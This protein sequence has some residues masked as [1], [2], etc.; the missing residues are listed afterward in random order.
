MQPTKPMPS[1]AEP[2]ILAGL[3][4]PI[5]VRS[6]NFSER[7]P[8][9]LPPTRSG[10]AYTGCLALL[11]DERSPIGWIVAPASAD[12]SVSFDWASLGDLRPAE[13]NGP[14]ASPG[15][16]APPAELDLSVVVSTCANAPGLLACVE[17]LLESDARPREIVVV[18]NRPGSSTVEAELAER[19]PEESRIRYVEES[20]PGLSFARNAGLAVVQGELVA[21]T[22]D[23][24][25][26][27]RAWTAA[28]AE[29][30]ADLAAPD[31]LT[32]LIAPYELETPAQLLVEE[33]AGYGKGMQSRVYSLAAPPP[34]Q[35]LFPYA[36]G[37]YAS[38]ANLAFRTSFL[39][40]IGGFDPALGAGTRAR[41]GED[42]DICIRLFEAGG[43]L[44]Y[45][46][47]AIVWHRHR[48]GEAHLERGA[49][50][51]GTALGAV[52]GKH[53]LTSPKRWDILRRIPPAVGYFLDPDSR[54]NS[55][56][57]PD[58]PRRLSVIEWFGLAYGPLA[59]LVSH[60]FPRR[61]R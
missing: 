17:S 4:A 35:P 59:Y 55:G 57:G 44:T 43:T 46:P 37:H 47:A 1:P 36:A 12:G 11:R 16:A 30:F 28:I 58:F 5:A 49:F 53:I 23:D 56:R 26:V 50:D 29:A 19:F 15:D 31:C 25:R 45:E 13:A 34:D 38:G 52:L 18:E 60:I 27:D 3:D 51:M 9:R 21:F 48:D 20:R 10:R 8:L 33:F 42:L 41:G 32:G 61:P 6:L 2:L 39:H 24:V 7:A 22:D 54:K 14:D 40:D